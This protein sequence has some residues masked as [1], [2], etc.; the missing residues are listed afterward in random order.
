MRSDHGQEKSVKLRL[1]SVFSENN[2]LRQVPTC[3]KLNIFVFYLDS[4]FDQKLSLTKVALIERKNSFLIKTVVNNGNY[5]FVI[6]MNGVIVREISNIVPRIHKKL[7]IF[8]TTPVFNVPSDGYLTDL[9]YFTTQ[10]K[11]AKCQRICSTGY[12]KTSNQECIMCS[13]NYRRQNRDGFSN[14]K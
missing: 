12:A 2:T 4:A 8:T 13:E 5:N 1:N 7:K 11:H 3:Q 9:K 10:R 14:A 6:S